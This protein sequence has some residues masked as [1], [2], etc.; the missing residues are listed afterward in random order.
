MQDAAE[1]AVPEAFEDFGEHEPMRAAAPAAPT[2]QTNVGSNMNTAKRTMRG[3][4]LTC[5]KMALH[6]NGLVLLS[7]G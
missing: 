6:D 3:R 4:R 7:C 2:V 1:E 5:C